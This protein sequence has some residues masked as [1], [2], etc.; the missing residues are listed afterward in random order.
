METQEAGVRAVIVP[1]SGGVET[2][3]TVRVKLL[4]ERSSLRWIPEQELDAA[5]LARTVDEAMGSAVRLP[6]FARDG[7]H[8]TVRSVNRLLGRSGL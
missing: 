1:Y 3:Q 5:K 8:E 2:E 7:A 6:R 4:A